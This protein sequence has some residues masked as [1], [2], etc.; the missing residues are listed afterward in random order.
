VEVP[1]PDRA[2]R[3]SIFRVHLRKAEHQAGRQLFDPPDGAGWDRLL[4]TTEGFSGADIA[5]IVRRALEAK[6][7]AGATDGQIT[8]AE[9]LEQAGTVSRP[10]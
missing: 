3:R 8:L 7:R 9:L 2:G 5:E 6:V 4:E 10:W 1:L